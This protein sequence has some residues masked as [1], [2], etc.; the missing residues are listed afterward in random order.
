MHLG[1]EAMSSLGAGTA[2]AGDKVYDKDY[3]KVS[4]VTRGSQL[5]CPVVFS[6][7]IWSRILAA[8][9]NRSLVMARIFSKYL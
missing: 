8:S 2:V 6:V 9:S 7:L 1:M 3:D 4:S 5:E